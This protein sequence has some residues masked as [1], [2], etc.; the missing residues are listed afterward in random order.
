MLDSP[1]KVL[2]AID[3][4]RLPASV[5]CGSPAIAIAEA[6]DVH[7]TTL[8][9][10]FASKQDLMT[11]I[12]A[13]PLVRCDQVAWSLFGISMAGWNAICS[14]MLSGLWLASVRG[15]NRVYGAA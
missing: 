15:R 8:F 4:M 3:A 5:G 14:A 7:V 13:A 11:A 2:A 12:E 10:H 1:W 6:A 9:T